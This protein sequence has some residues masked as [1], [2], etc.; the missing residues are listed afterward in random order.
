MVASHVCEKPSVIRYAAG[1]Q[2]QTVVP[3]IWASADKALNS[4]RQSVAQTEEAM[5]RER[6]RPLA[7]FRSI[8]LMVDQRFGQSVVLVRATVFRVF[9]VSLY[10]GAIVWRSTMDCMHEFG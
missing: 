1:E 6:G 4:R 2:I 8:A 10:N 9:V 7:R 3:K 5:S